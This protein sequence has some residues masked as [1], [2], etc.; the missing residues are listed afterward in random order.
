MLGHPV[1]LFDI[2]D[3]DANLGISLEK[4]YAAY[5]LW[6]SGR[7]DGPLL[8]NEVAIEDMCL[9]FV[10]PGMTPLTICRV[11][12]FSLGCQEFHPQVG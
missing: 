7:Q 2:R 1:D 11:W 4:L 9:T 10:L 12:L 6:T 8:M 5:S 3:I